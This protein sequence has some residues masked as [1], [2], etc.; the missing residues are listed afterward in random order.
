MSETGY[1]LSFS[2]SYDQFI[3]EKMRQFG[4]ALVETM[5]KVGSRPLKAMNFVQC[6]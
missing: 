6:Y 1:N 4:D 5:N 3:T 2:L